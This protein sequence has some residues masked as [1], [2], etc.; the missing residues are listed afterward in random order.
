VARR[1][2]FIII[3]EAYIY[4]HFSEA[5]IYYHVGPLGEAIARALAWLQSLLLGWNA[6]GDSG[7]VAIADALRQNSTIFTL[8]MQWNKVP[9]C[10]MQ[11]RT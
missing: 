3:S 2:T 4:Y 1:R 11:Q 5:Y 6:L 8:E 9:A 7:A 10:I